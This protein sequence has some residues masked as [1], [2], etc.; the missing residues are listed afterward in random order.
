MTLNHPLLC[1]GLF[2]C[3]LWNS[4]SAATWRVNNTPDTSPDYTTIQDA[5]N[6]AATGDIVL[7]EGSSTPYQGFTLSTKRLTL[8]G[9]GYRLGDNLGTPA[10]K[11]A[12][13][14]QNPSYVQQGGPSWTT[15]GSLVLGLHFTS[16]LTLEACRGVTVSRCLFDSATLRVSG[17]E[18]VVSQC[19]IR[20]G[21]ELDSRASGTR[22]ENNLFESG[23]FYL[24]GSITPWVVY[25]TNNVLGNLSV[26]ASSL[27]L[28]LDNNIVTGSVG[29]LVSPS[30]DIVCRNN[31][32]NGPLPSGLVGTGNISFTSFDAVMPN[33]ASNTASFDGK[34]QLGPGSPALNAGTDGSHIGPFGGLNP[35]I[36]SG[37]P[38]LPSIDELSVP[39]IVRPGGDVTIQIKV[40]DRP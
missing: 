30:N 22:V 11:M 12:A 6:A 5:I 38:P 32:I 18:N 7:V 1:L 17:P 36:L 31:L 13:I 3:G 39:Q 28:V 8:I 25:I 21:L 29:S 27:S 40:G 37:V 35:Y 10:D 2:L 19:F 16:Q 14:I 26:S 34:Y 9:P 33:Y 15:S 23:N 24:S 4:L 20:G